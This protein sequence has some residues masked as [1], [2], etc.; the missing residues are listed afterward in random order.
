MKYNDD[1]S[2]SALRD[3]DLGKVV[4]KLI[5]DGKTVIVFFQIEDKICMLSTSHIHTLI[6]EDIIDFLNHFP[7]PN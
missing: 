6:R 3:V 1:L 2:M 4:D 7:E 5:D